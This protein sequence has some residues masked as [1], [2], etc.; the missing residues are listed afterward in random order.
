MESQ[1]APP[2][3]PPLDVQT[4]VD[5]AGKRSSAHLEIRHDPVEEG[6]WVREYAEG[7]VAFRDPLVEQARQFA[8][9][10]QPAQAII[11]SRMALEIP[12]AGDPF[13]F[14]Q[15]TVMNAMNLPHEPVEVP[16]S[17]V[18]GEELSEQDRAYLQPSWDRLHQMG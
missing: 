13:L 11:A 3:G 10:E 8:A 14:A 9:A 12:F 1:L 6:Q 18:Q 15:D 2:S 7:R 16:K 4:W 5:N 17:M